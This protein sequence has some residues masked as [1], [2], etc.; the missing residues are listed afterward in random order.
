MISTY[1]AKFANIYVYVRGLF[2]GHSRTLAKIPGLFQDGCLF[3][4][5]PGHSRTFQ[6]SIHPENVVE[7]ATGKEVGK[8]G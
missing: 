3:Q 4:D 7:F 5:I 6:D 1:F 8:A 2:P